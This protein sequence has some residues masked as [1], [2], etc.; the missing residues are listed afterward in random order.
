MNKTTMIKNYRMFNACDEYLIGLERGNDLFVVN[1][2]KLM[3]RWINVD[4]TTHSKGY[5]PKIDMDID[6]FE[7]DKLIEKHTLFS[8]PLTEL[9]AQGQ[10]SKGHNLE[11]LIWKY[12]GV[13]GYKPDKIGFWHD[14]DLTVNNIKYQIKYNHAQIVLEQTLETLK[15]FKKYGVTPPETFKS[16]IQKIVE[17]MK[18]EHKKGR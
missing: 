7:R 4:H 14:G 2:P 16:N 10:D 8:C 18:Q 5:K 6:A 11:A 17:K 13:D 9:Y 12:F 15:V 3:P 1:T